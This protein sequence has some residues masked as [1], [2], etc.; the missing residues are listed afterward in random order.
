MSGLVN[1]PVIPFLGGHP[2]VVLREVHMG[3]EVRYEVETRK[4]VEILPRDDFEVLTAGEAD[5]R[6]CRI[7]YV[8]DAAR[9]SYVNC[10]GKED[11]FHVPRKVAFF[12]VSVSAVPSGYCPQCNTYFFGPMEG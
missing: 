3:D 10:E 5:A 8:D 4:E 7:K 2:G 12:P 6:G 1:A 11:A 9:G